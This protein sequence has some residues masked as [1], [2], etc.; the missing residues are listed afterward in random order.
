[1]AMTKLKCGTGKFN[2]SNLLYT[3]HCSHFYETFDKV[4]KPNVRIFIRISPD[5]SCKRCIADLKSDW[6]ER[7]PQFTGAEMSTVI[8][9][10]LFVNSL[11]KQEL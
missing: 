9:I 10:E 11:G 1:M 4:I 3:Y 8:G 5:E 7:L 6:F 2:D